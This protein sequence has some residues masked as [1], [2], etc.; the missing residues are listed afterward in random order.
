[1]TRQYSRNRNASSFHC[2]DW[3]F[4]LRGTA[5]TKRRGQAQVW[6][7]EWK[8]VIALR[9][10]GRTKTWLICVDCV[11]ASQPHQ[12]MRQTL[13]S[14][15]QDASKDRRLDPAGRSIA[16]RTPDGARGRAA[17]GPS[18]AEG[19]GSHHC[20]SQ[21]PLSLLHWCVPAARIT[22]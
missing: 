2:C 18:F 14:M 17:E 5:K 22:T 15:C 20:T 11:L 7:R 13:A 19:V 10:E 8:A 1:M 16:G 12:G 6:Q 3:A 9:R 21:G 4:A